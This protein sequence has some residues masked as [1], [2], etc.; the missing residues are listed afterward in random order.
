MDEKLSQKLSQYGV[1]PTPIRILVLE[2]LQKQASAESIS[3]L[4]EKLEPTERATL[5]RTL[6]TFEHH[7]I[8]HHIDDG[9]GIT[10]YALCSS[11]CSDLAH[12]DMHVHFHCTNCGT[13]TCLPDTQIPAVQLPE[14]FKAQDYQ[15]VIR[16]VCFCCF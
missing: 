11:A 5:Y 2:K 7:G 10:K 12:Y 14:N 1:K 4:E 8:V 6:Q 15:L 16:G 9:T 13:T 3:D